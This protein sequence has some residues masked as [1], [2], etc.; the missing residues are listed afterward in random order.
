M[1]Y[2]CIRNKYGRTILLILIHKLT[3]FHFDKIADW[4]G[5]EPFLKYIDKSSNKQGRG[6]KQKHILETSEESNVS[7][8]WC[9]T[10]FNGW[11]SSCTGASVHHVVV[12][13]PSRV[14]L[15]FQGSSAQITWNYV[16]KRTLFWYIA[17]LP[18]HLL[19]SH[20][21]YLFQKLKSY[22]N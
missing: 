9:A 6:R 22:M 7:L 2:A 11:R 19:I 1:L 17:H 3:K 18:E 15:L 13:A 8:T 21:S 12:L 5:V 14:L 4:K 10:P 20:L 16:A